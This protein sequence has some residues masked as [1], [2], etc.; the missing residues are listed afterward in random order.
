MHNKIIKNIIDQ[1]LDIQQNKL[2]I[3]ENFRNKIDNLSE[4]QALR[5]PFPELHSVAELVSHILVWRKESILKLKGKDSFLS[6][7][8]PENWITNE[9]IK[10]K[11]WEILKKE[12]YQSQYDIIAQIENEAD[13]YLDKEYS[14]GYKYK[15]LIEGLLHHD[16]YH[17]GQIGIVIKL[18]NLQLLKERE[19]IVKNYIDVYNSFDISKMTENISKDIVFENFQNGNI[20]MRLKGLRDFIEQAKVASNYF[21]TRNQNIITL[22]HEKDT[23]KVEIDY[24]GVLSVDLSDDLKKGQILK[25]KGESIFNFFD[26]EIIKLVDKS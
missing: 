18:L 23:V 15:Y 11:G 12:F 17:L 3:D 2:W 4:K 20:T 10:I 26:D 24:E 14:G 8:S 21:S 16:L 9:E 1:L 5:R 22:T 13:D 7:E 6:V 25:L 19:Q